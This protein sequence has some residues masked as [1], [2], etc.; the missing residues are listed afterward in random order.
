MKRRE[1][2]RDKREGEVSV[3]RSEAVDDHWFGG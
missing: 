2:G 1:E 3:I